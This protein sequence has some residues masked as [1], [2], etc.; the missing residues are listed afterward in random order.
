MI[1]SPLLSWNGLKLN[2]SFAVHIVTPKS[3]ELMGMVTQ[4]NQAV[5]S[6]RK[7]TEVQYLFCIV[8]LQL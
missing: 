7:G 6:R 2:A 3:P 4:L 5:V 1:V 8:L